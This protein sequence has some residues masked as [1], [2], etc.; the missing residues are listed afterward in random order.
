MVGS[1]AGAD[2]DDLG[3]RP[4]ILKAIAHAAHHPLDDVDVVLAAVKVAH[5]RDGCTGD[6]DSRG[7]LD[8][9]ASEPAGG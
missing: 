3:R 1:G 7:Q 6:A 2:V 5:T 8:R 4:V 9:I